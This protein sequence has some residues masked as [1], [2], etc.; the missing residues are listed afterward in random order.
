MFKKHFTYLILVVA[1][2][3]FSF[4]DVS[5]ADDGPP[6]WVMTENFIPPES[7]NRPTG[8][9]NGTLSFT[10]TEMNVTPDWLPDSDYSYPWYLWYTWWYPMDLIAAQDPP[11]AVPLFDLDATVFPGLEIQLFTTKEGD[12][13]PVQRGIIRKP[14]KDRTES[15]WEI[16]IGPGKAWKDN[17]NKEKRWKGWNKAAFPFSLVHSQEGE[18]LLG[19]A[20]FYYKGH[21]VS[22]L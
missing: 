16:I 9:F 7:A 5:Y 22:K 17:K 19:L 1:I 2:L 4:F 13:V 20:F 6:S 18:A 8:H 3:T 15:F 14:V 21:E 10:T 11:G 12:L